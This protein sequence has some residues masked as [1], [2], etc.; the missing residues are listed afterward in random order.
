[1]KTCAKTI[2]NIFDII[3]GIILLPF[4]LPLL[5]MLSIVILI[6][7]GPPIMFSQNRV[8]KNNRVFKFYKFRTMKSPIASGTTSTVDEER[9]T[10]L[11]RL[12]RRTSIDEL[13]SIFNL[14]KGDVSLVGP[15]PLL[16][17]YLP[18]YNEFQ[19]RRHEVKPGITGLAQVNGRNLI[20]WAQK[21]NYDVYYVD[22]QTLLLDFKILIRTVVKVFK[23]SGI[24][25]EDSEIMPE[26]MGEEKKK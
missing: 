9:I 15:R 18:R 8:G 17:K 22:H 13:P 6:I 12:L 16:E 25:P 26:F 5:L 7:D 19:A 24:S 20:S 21:F 23:R 4:M 1:M 11:G 2:K 10:S 14:V 3:I